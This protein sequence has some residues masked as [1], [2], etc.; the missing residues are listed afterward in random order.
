MS[1]AVPTDQNR[2]RR[3]TV[4]TLTGLLASLALALGAC[5]SGGTTNSDDVTIN[6]LVGADG[7]D[8]VI[9][10]AADMPPNLAACVGG[11]DSLSRS[12]FQDECVMPYINGLWVDPAGLLRP[13]DELAAAAED[14]LVK[15][16]ADGKW[17]IYYSAGLSAAGKDLSKMLDGDAKLADQVVLK[18]LPN[19]LPVPSANPKSIYNQAGLLYVPNSYVTPGGIFNEQYGWD[20]YFIIA[21]L[22]RSAEYVLDHPEG[23]YWSP[24]D[25]R[26]V[27]LDPPTARALAKRLFTIA[28]GMADN[29]AFMVDFYAGFVPNGNRI[30]YLTRSQPPLLAAESLLIY[31]FAEQHTD[32]VPY[33]GQETLAPFL[34]IRAPTSYGQWIKKEILPSARKYYDYFTDPR[35]TTFGARTNPRVARK[36]GHKLFS[37][38]PDGVGPVPEIVR[39]QVPG[40][41]NYYRQ[42]AAYFAANPKA[43]PHKRFYD[44]GAGDPRFHLTQD[45]YLA[46]RSVRASGYDLSGRYGEVGQHA[47]DFAPVDLHTLLFQMAKDINEMATI[48]GR[49]PI[50]AQRELDGYVS[51]MDKLMW[52]QTTDGP[53]SYYSDAW[54]RED[55]QAQPDPY[56]YGTTFYPLWAQAVT[57]E[58]RIADIV[59]TATTA[60]EVSQ[61]QVFYLY[62]KDGKI[63]PKRVKRNGQ[64]STC[65]LSDPSDP[66][67]CTDRFTT[68]AQAPVPLVSDTNFGIPTSLKLTGNQWDF[69]NGWA[70]VQYFAA[71][72]LDR[73]GRPDLTAAVDNG[74]TSAVEI[75]FA[76][77]GTIIEKYS[78]T[79]PAE[80]VQ[81]TSGYS[82]PQV[83]F[84]WTNGVYVDSLSRSRR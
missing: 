48:A 43:N 24:T 81:V 27:Q 23:Q 12:Q 3:R 55:A 26:M 46:D 50:V 65:E 15:K 71:I 38:H 4:T 77:T 37:Y 9:K 22:L 66:G 21:G 39:S 61:D 14:W 83:G 72:G 36:D 34:G 20:S 76:A 63:T 7:R 32:L 82:K 75:G 69:S 33:Q 45:F 35:T 57:D 17:P 58:G 78:A 16:P 40:N 31:R 41:A 60:G 54:I 52:R 62:G 2:V 70:P 56:L 28:K 30:Y 67:S 19:P 10:R 53:G 25:S 11:A 13:H 64:I 80:Q 1:L 51:A 29:Q 18:K 59:R 74:W 42:V 6:G 49:P 84:G 73:A 44:V 47:A 68:V 8:I 5:S 79:N